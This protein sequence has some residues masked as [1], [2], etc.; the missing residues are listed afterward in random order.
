MTAWRVTPPTSRRW[1]VAPSPASSARAH[2]HRP[3]ERAVRPG[4]AHAHQCVL[5]AAAHGDEELFPVDLD[6]HDVLGG[7]AGPPGAP[8]RPHRVRPSRPGAR[9]ARQGV[10]GGREGPVRV[11]L[12]GDLVGHPVEQAGV[13][14]ALDD[15]GPGEEPAQVGE[16]GRE[17]G[18]AGPAQGP[19]EAAQRLRPVGAVGDDLGEERVVVGRDLAAALDPR[20][21]PHPGGLGEVHVGHPARRRQEP[22]PRVLGVE[23]GLQR[24]APQRH[25]GLAEAQRLARGHPDLLFDQVEAGD[26]LG[27]GVL[28][29]QARVHLDEV[30]LV[31]AVDRHEE[32]DG[33]EALVV[34]RA[35]R[36]ERR[37]QEP[38]A[39]A[40]REARGRALLDD[41]L[42]AALEGALALAQVD[43]VPEGVAQHLDL[44]V[45]G[46]PEVP[47]DEEPG[48]PEGGPRLPGGHRDHAREAVEVLDDVHPLAPAAGR[49]LHEEGE[50]DR[51]GGG[52]QRRRRAVREGQPVER[53]D[54]RP[55]HPRL[56]LELV[57]HGAHR[58]G[59][60]P[61]EGDPAPPAGV[62]E[63]G[64][65]RE[66]AVAGVDGVGAEALGGVEH[67]VEVEVALGRRRRAQVGGDVGV[68]HV[69]SPPV[70]VAVE[71]GHRHPHRAQR[72]GDAHRDLAAVGDQDPAE[73]HMRKTP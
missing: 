30:V 66:E 26:A 23:A 21:D 64:V 25:V 3:E 29:L 69:A 19:L 9:Q 33:A 37:A 32:L 67:G 5:V 50:A 72:P 49:R 44:D 47:L 53:R 22:A 18:H 70:R 42:V 43:E 17:P 27:H 6:A 36:L 34:D 46:A 56:G 71:R 40:R 41:L 8:G 62:G 59:A 61:D 1:P 20:V 28:D 12:A 63:V 52:A 39:Q 57:G 54:P 24:V 10:D 2:A 38:V 51:L 60:R 58:R 65:L 7:P 15:L 14:S 55:A 68:A 35:G 73:H 16:V 4:R 31:L 11:G 13:E 48:V 45:A